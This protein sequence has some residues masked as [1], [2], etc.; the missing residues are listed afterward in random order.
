LNLLNTNLPR[1]IG[2]AFFALGSL[3]FAFAAGAL[4]LYAVRIDPAKAYSVFFSSSLASSAGIVAIFVAATP[5]IINGLGISIAFKAGIWNIGAE[6]QMLAGAVLAAVGGIYISL[7]FPL[8][9]LLLMILGLIGGAAWAAIPA[10]LKAFLGANEIVVTLMFNYIMILLTQYLLSGVLNSGGIAYA[11]QRT[12]PIQ[13]TAQYPPLIPGTALHFGVLVAILLVP[14]VYFLM[15]RTVFGFR[16]RVVGSSEKTAKYA[17]IRIPVLIIMAML[18]SGAFAGLA[19]MGEVSGVHYAL[20]VGITS[21]LGYTA[22][23]VAV[24]GRLHPVGVFL[25]AILFGCLIVG[26][27][28]MQNFANV[29]SSLVVFLQGLIV[30]IVLAT[31]I[32]RVYG[33]KRIV[34]SRGKVF[35]ARA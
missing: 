3:L 19:G 14:A 13:V 1:V 12:V 20:L 31:E 23:L 4:I 10:I 28:G 9:V 27:Q 7:P 22:V 34:A 5:L 32:I 18:L 6:G 24:L 16:L 21:G 15:Y 33:A 29:P 8:H 26:G 17:G 2:E 11:G 25:A 35:I 30:L